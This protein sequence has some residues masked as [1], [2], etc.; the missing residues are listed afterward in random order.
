MRCYENTVHH[1]SCDLLFVL[2]ARV[3]S[4][5]SRT[6]NADLKYISIFLQQK[7]NLSVSLS[8]SVIR[9]ILMSH[10]ERNQS[11]SMFSFFPS[12]QD[13]HFGVFISSAFYGSLFFPLHQQLESNSSKSVQVSVD[14]R[15]SQECLSLQ[16]LN[17]HDPLYMHPPPFA[18]ALMQL[19]RHNYRQVSKDR[20]HTLVAVQSPEATTHSSFAAFFHVFFLGGGVE[21]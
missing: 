18:A 16:I 1:Q 17:A 10:T 14:S 12:K 21:K 5:W 15:C 2:S 6:N 4:P 11:K 20:I 3:L 19:K 7:V 8:I 9:R 13:V